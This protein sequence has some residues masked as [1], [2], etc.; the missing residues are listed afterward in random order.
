MLKINYFNGQLS[1][2]FVALFSG[3]MIQ[4]AALGLIG[5]FL[6]IFLFLKF[7][8]NVI[9][10]YLF[11]LVGH[12]A[13]A[14]ILPYGARFLNKI[15]L[16]KSLQVS[17]FFD[18]AFYI[19]IY[20]IDRNPVLFITLSMVSIVLAR[21]FFWLPYHTEFAKFTKRDD[22]GKEYSL[23]EATKG[24]LDILMPVAAGILIGVF[25]FKSV[26]LISIILMLSSSIPFL[27]LEDTDEKFSWGYIE[28]FRNFFSKENRKVVLANLANG[29]ENIVG[30]IIWPIFIWEI[31]KGNYFAVGS[32]SSLIVL[33]TI[34]L[35]LTVGKYTDLFD[36]RRMIRYGSFLYAGGWL[37]K[38]F[39]LTA[40]QIFLAGTYHNLVQIFKNTPFDVL[41]Y[42]L[43]ADHGHYVDEYT[44]LKEIAVQLGKVLMLVFAIVITLL[45]GMSWTF[46]LAALA[47]L[48]I[49]LL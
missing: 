48:F 39:V 30:I 16:K 46:A 17:V 34:I 40:F 3:R 29:A 26:F 1:Q 19:F 12:L 8:Y 41:N 43:M 49:N 32:L 42:Q 13:Y 14:L 27:T 10:V 37:V 7:D 25:G 22:R 47:S 28:T 35:Q 4:F 45:F 23:M 2:G 20:F 38:M 6:P 15:G 36:K 24:F 33:V 31:L 11:Y 18:S 5:L 44:V 21:L 9:Y